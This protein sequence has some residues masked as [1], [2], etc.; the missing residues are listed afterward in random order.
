MCIKPRL[1]DV[2]RLVSARIERMKIDDEN[3]ECDSKYITFILG[4][5][6]RGD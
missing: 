1:Y 5:E 2:N 6:S 3:D 4:E